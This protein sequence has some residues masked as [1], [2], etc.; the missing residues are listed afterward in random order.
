[1]APMR[2][3]WIEKMAKRS[4][5]AFILPTLLLCAA[6]LAVY[7]FLPRTD[8]YTLQG[9]AI[10]LSLDGRPLV[11]GNTATLRAVSTCG[12]F[13]VSLDGAGFGNG[14]PLLSAPFLLKEGSH[15]FFAQGNGC[16]STLVFGVIA[17][18]CGA[19]ETKE[20]EKSGC[21][22]TCKCAGGIFSECALPKKACQPGEKVGCSTNGCSFGHMMCNQ[23]GTGFGKCLP[24]LGTGL[25]TCSGSQ[26]CT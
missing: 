3:E 18:E 2:H 17:R 11:D 9:G 14:E 19:N 25:A 10:S 13:D 12:A 8:T 5:L 4:T 22:G 15:S 7:F 23:C 21:P 6:L 26:N 20:C 24:D 1:M 16:N